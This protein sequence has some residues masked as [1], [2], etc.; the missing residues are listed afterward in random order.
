MKYEGLALPSLH[1]STIEKDRKLRILDCDLDL[2]L[3]YSSVSLNRSF[4][5]VLEQNKFSKKVTSNRD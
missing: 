1:Q 4:R 3:T 5:I 2:A